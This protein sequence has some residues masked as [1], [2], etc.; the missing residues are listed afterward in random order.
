LVRS[1]I[2]RFDKYLLID[3]VSTADS[4]LDTPESQRRFNAWVLGGFALIALILG[5]VGIYGV[6]VYWVS[7]RVQEIG[8]RMALGA[9]RGDVLALVIAQGL[10]IAIAGLGIGIVAAFALSRF[11]SSLLYEIKPN[12]PVTFVTVSLIMLAVALLA[13]YIPARRATKVDPMVALRYE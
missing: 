5:A 9:Q 7:Q 12:D 2:H 13:C 6:L 11:L 8:V 4:M 3:R 1:E 10:S